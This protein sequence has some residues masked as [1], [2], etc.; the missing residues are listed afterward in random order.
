M[1][2]AGCLLST[3]M[4]CVTSSR[5]SALWHVCLSPC[6]ISMRCSRQLTLWHI[7]LITTDASHSVLLL[8]RLQLSSLLPMWHMLRL[9]LHS[10]LLLLLLTGLLLLALISMLGPL[11]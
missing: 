9:W 3:D 6:C 4:A 1:L 2:L 8:L 5:H 10:R 11:C 7:S